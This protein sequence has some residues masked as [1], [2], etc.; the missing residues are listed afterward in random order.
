MKT[1]TIRNAY[2]VI[3]H[4]FAVESADREGTESAWDNAVAKIT[5]DDAFFR[6]YCE[7]SEMTDAEITEA[8]ALKSESSNY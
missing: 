7:D 4:E 6:A 1:T 3:V 5:G 2:E 8:L